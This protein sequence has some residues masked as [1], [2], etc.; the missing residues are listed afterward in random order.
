MILFVSHYAGRTGAPIALLHI[1]RW[2]RK[3]TDLRF[4]ILLRAGGELEKDFALIE[5]TYLYQSRKRWLKWNAPLTVNTIS[6]RELRDRDYSL[7]YSNTIMNADLIKSSFADS[8]PL[9]THCHEMNYWMNRAGAQEMQYIIKRTN[10]FIACSMPAARCLEQRGAKIGSVEIIPEPF[11][12]SKK[13]N[14]ESLKIRRSLGIPDNSFV[15]I[16]GG[17]EC[18]RKGKDL[19][20]QL[21]ILLGRKLKIRFDLIWLGSSL[22]EP[23]DYWHHSSTEYAGVTGNIHWPGCVKNPEIY[24]NAADCF[25]M[26]S[27]ED[28]M[29][30]IAIEAGSM[31]LPVICFESAGGTADWVGLS[32]GGRV[33]SY[34]DIAQVSEAIEEYANK[35]DLMA[36]AGALAAEYCMKEFSIDRIGPKVYESLKG[37]IDSQ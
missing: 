36:K 4:E 7:V 29:P 2:L 14:H 11:V 22:A 35:P 33:V 16:S 21:G 26:L 20:A 8:I 28:P 12:P 25:V 3:K 24:L 34:L 10:K 18:L 1:L 19:F 32:H 9:I 27:R 37:L 30:L 17:E 13:P 6:P 15:I 23:F 5:K 31:G